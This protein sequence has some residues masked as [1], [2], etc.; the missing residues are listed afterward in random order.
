MSEPGD[1]RIKIKIG[2]LA[3]HSKLKIRDTIPQQYIRPG[4]TIGQESGSKG[5]RFRYNRCYASNSFILEEPDFDSIG[6]QDV[7]IVLEDAGRNRTRIY[8]QTLYR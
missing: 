2:A 8:C 6:E 5:F 7:G 1:Y 3:Y 4:D